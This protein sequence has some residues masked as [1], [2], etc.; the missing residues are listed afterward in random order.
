MDVSKEIQK[1]LE[2]PNLMILGTLRRDN[3][4]QMTPVWFCFVNG[5]FEVSTTT[6][7]VK[8]KNISLNPHVTFVIVDKNNPY[9][10]VQTRGIATITKEKA[11]ELIDNLSKRYTGVTPY[12]G[13][14]EH[15]EDRVIITITPERI[16]GRGI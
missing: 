5:I 4:I 3:T 12:Q 8:Y 7:R 10:F 1:F 14:P 9:R 2:E 6:Q 13:D 11:H 15:K 16:T